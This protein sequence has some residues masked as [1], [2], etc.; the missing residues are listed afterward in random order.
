MKT[1]AKQQVKDAL[2]V[3]KAA[4]KDLKKAS[5]KAA[6][7]VLLREL[8]TT[9]AFPARYRVHGGRLGSTVLLIE[10][11]SIAQAQATQYGATL[12]DRGVDYGS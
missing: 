3:L 2:A 8:D 4:F 5:D 12:D 6:L 7:R 9:Q 10:D 11:G 1:A